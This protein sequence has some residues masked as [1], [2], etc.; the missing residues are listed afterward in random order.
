LQ[1]EELKKKFSK[2]TLADSRKKKEKEVHE[3]PGY[4]IGWFGVAYQGNA[5]YKRDSENESKPHGL[6]AKYIFLQQDRHSGADENCGMYVCITRIEN[7]K[8]KRGKKTA[9]DAHMLP[10]PHPGHHTAEP[11]TG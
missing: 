6:A 11:T 7:A 5:E 2:K 10:T 8:H 4:L 3:T 9:V 1:G